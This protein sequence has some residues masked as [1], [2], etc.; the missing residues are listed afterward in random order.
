MAAPVSRVVLPDDVRATRA[1]IRAFETADLVLIA[2]SN[3]FVSIEPI[4]N[5]YPIRALL[6]DLPQA[7]I[8]VSP[9]VG[10]RRSKVRRPR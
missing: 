10:G 8:A 9:I 4:L 7:V 1:V 5:V 6:M 2:P 3:P